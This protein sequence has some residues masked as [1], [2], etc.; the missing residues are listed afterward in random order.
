MVSWHVEGTLT[1][2]ATERA[3]RYFDG[4][5]DYIGCVIELGYGIAPYCYACHAVLVCHQHVHPGWWPFLWIVQHNDNAGQSY[6]LLGICNVYE[7]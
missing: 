3:S 4:S 1:I 5:T 6:S 7:R 2:V